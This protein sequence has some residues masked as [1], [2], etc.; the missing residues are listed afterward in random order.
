MPTPDRL[1]YSARVALAAMIL[2]AVAETARSQQLFF[3]LF[4]LLLL[5]RDDPMQTAKAAFAVSLIAISASAIS[6]VIGALVADL[7]WLRIIV[8]GLSIFLVT[9]LSRGLRQ[10]L[11]GV[12]FPV[13]C[14]Q[15]LIA[16][17]TVPDPQQAVERALWFALMP[18]FGV[19]LATAVEVLWP[20]PKPIERVLRGVDDRVKSVI[21]ELKVKSGTDTT[22]Q[23]AAAAARLNDLSLIGSQ[24]LQAAMPA[25]LA[26]RLL[27]E[28][29]R[30]RLNAI[31]LGLEP[32]VELGTALSR[33]SNQDFTEGQRTY[34]AHLAD[35]I[36][37]FANNVGRQE[38][39]IACAKPEL[40]DAADSPAHG[41]GAVLVAMGHLLERMRMSWYEE[42][43]ILK[44]FAPQAALP[45]RKQQWEPLGPFFATMDVRHALKITLSAMIFYIAYSAAAWQGLSAALIACFIVAMDTIGATF[46]KLALFLAGSAIG[47]FVF[48]IGGIALVLSHIDNIVELL[49]YV[50]LVFFVAGWVVRGSQRISYAGTQIAMAFALVGLGGPTIPN[51]ITEPRD[52]FI[53]ILLG[54]VII[55]YVF[56]Y[57]W[58]EDALVKQRAK[59]S[60]L[61]ETAV[62]MI[63]LATQ[64]LPAEKKIGLARK[65]RATANN[66]IVATTDQGDAAIYD[67][68]Y[69]PEVQKWLDECLDKVQPLLLSGVI[70]IRY[71]VQVN[72]LTS[73]LD[74]ISKPAV[75]VQEQ[76]LL[77]LASAIKSGRTDEIPDSAGLKAASA[78]E[79]AEVLSALESFHQDATE[80]HCEPVV[81]LSRILKRRQEFIDEL[82][83]ATRGL[84]KAIGK[85]TAK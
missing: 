81:F 67:A 39:V 1:S 60:G 4:V 63:K 51:Q 16:F 23:E 53:G 46:R 41:P 58:P 34:A 7:T 8:I 44:G 14:V 70:Y 47:E 42:A 40:L 84:T 59:I 20:H 29:N 31:L 43:E 69:D 30:L 73:E 50:A 66:S 55:W 72:T 77:A 15:C 62:K 17:D 18:T 52:R 27:N 12:L 54:T 45:F 56:A 13:I 2:V 6:I 28:N 80:Q 64:D 38:T 74:A 82:T 49:L 22:E 83:W 26:E 78:K 19:A 3:A 79:T 71:S 48:G 61:V 10:P 25:I 11:L 33:Y 36:E 76:V 32:L 75:E 65:W 21:A 24:P 68:Y 9:I 5:P 37:Q 85:R 57:I 35:V